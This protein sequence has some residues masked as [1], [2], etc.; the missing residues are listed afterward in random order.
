MFVE[1][2]VSLAV[3]IADTK[4]IDDVSMELGVGE[5]AVYLGPSGCG[6]TTLMRIVGG[7]ETTTR[8]AVY[9]EGEKVTGPDRKKGMMFQVDRIFVFSA[10]PA[11]SIEEIQ[12]SEHVPGERS[13]DTKETEAFFH[14]RNHVRDVMRQQAKKGGFLFFRGR[15]YGRRI[16]SKRLQRAR[17]AEK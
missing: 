14:L 5:F 7:L 1:N 11:S 9:L 17:V 13:I 2:L 10:R 12:V 3:L 8:A 15:L 6:K 4:V 16:A